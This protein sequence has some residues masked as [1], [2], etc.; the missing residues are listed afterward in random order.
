MSKLTPILRRSTLKRGDR[1]FR[2]N[3]GL[4]AYGNERE[5]VFATVCR[6]H[7]NPEKIVVLYD[8]WQG[9]ENGA[10]TTVAWRRFYRVN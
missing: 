1:I 5:F 7:H 8:G 9:S 10:R 4:G 3:T 6:G 2:I